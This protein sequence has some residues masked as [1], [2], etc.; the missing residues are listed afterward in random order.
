MLNTLMNILLSAVQNFLYYAPILILSITVHEFC[1]AYTAK[2]LG[3]DTAYLQGRVTLNPLKHLDP[4]GAVCM[5]L[6]GFGWGAPCP[7]PYST[8]A[9]QN[10]TAPL[11]R[12]WGRCPTLRWPV[13]SG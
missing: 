13:F 7:F 1:H 6:F 11:F 9:I 12:S 8:S 3:D 5:L 4:V 2:R 10:G